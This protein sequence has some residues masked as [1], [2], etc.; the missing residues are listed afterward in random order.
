[1][2]V[3]KFMKNEKTPKKSNV[4]NTKLINT[5]KNIYFTPEM[6]GTTPN[7]YNNSTGMKTTAKL[8]VSINA[9]S[10]ATVAT[11]YTK[12][13]QPKRLKRNNRLLIDTKI[14]VSKN[15]TPV[16]AYLNAK[17]KQQLQQHEFNDVSLKSFIFFLI[18]ACLLLILR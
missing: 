3:P 12:V 1:M 2:K 15:E 14:N 4:T 7:I 5:F 13:S 9:S 18:S 8:N 10:S 17:N 6:A 11:R 16:K